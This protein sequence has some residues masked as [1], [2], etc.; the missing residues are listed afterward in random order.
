MTFAAADAKVS[1]YSYMKRNCPMATDSLRCARF[2][3]K[4]EIGICYDLA[5]ARQKFNEVVKGAI[6]MI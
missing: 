2:T 3:L 5:L 1:P 6:F 4:V